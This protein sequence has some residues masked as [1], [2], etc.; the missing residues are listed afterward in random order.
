M[1]RE[2]RDRG[3]TVF[4]SSHVLSEI[5]QA[6]DT[7]AILRAGHVVTVSDVETLRQSAV[8]HVRVGF[9]H[10][11]PESARASLAAID[12]VSDVADAAVPNGAGA[13]TPGGGGSAASAPQARG[14]VLTA[15]ITGPIDPFIKLIARYTVSE[16][17][18]EEPDLEESVLRLYAAPDA[19]GGAEIG[20]TN[21]AG[22]RHSTATS[23]RRAR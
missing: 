16:L 15:T 18:V 3:A 2:A 6:A 7:V 23:R 19:P 5:Q 21:P 22:A 9:T 8:R 12:G 13:T 14:A 1:V 10:A 17:T 20:P 11:P 4:L